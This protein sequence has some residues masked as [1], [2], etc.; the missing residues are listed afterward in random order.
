MILNFHNVEELVFYDE[1]LKKKIPEFSDIFNQWAFSKQHIGFR[2]LTNR[3]LSD[4]LNSLQEEQIVI[5]EH[6]FGAK[7]TI[8]KIDYQVVKNEDF[9]IEDA[10]LL[11]NND[12]FNF[13]IYRNKNRLHITFWR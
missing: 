4:F 1:K 5:L 10:E 3:L 7:I 6:Y 8:N 11:I 12:D 9:D 13:E 2:Q